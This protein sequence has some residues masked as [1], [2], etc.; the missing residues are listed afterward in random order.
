M[1]SLHSGHPTRCCDAMPRASCLWFLTVV[2][3]AMKGPHFF[4]VGWS[5]GEAKAWLLCSCD[6]LN[7]LVAMFLLGRLQGARGPGF[8]LPKCWQGRR[9]RL[10]AG[11]CLTSLSKASRKPL[12]KRPTDGQSIALGGRKAAYQNAGEGAGEVLKP[13]YC[14]TSLSDANRKPLWKGKHWKPVQ[15]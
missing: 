1:I 5:C 13:C 15:V 7:Q 6:V 8:C 11:Y 4:R 14:L 9:E 10:K 3:N 12:W 2:C